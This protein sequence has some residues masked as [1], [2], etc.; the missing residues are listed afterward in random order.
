M[1]DLCP[2]RRQP[3]VSPNTTHEV[4]LAL[5]VATQVDGPWR[6]MNVHEVVDDPALDVVLDPINQVPAAHVEDLDVGQ[7]PVQSSRLQSPKANLSAYNTFIIVNSQTDI[8]STP[9]LLKAIC[10]DPDQGWASPVLEGQTF[11]P[12]GRQRFHQGFHSVPAWWD[13][14]IQPSRTG[15]VLP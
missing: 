12:T 4:E 3:R 14:G 2:L 10:Y 15:F 6:H 1:S 7:V 9:T 11:C 13:A 8:Q 5:A